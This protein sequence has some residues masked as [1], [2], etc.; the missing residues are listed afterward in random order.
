MTSAVGRI[1][2]AIGAIFFLV[3]GG[4]AFL[5]PS[6]FFDTVATWEPYNPHN[7]R[8]AGAFQLGIGVSLA[9]AL[10][11]QRGSLIALAGAS[12]AGVAHAISHGVDY[13][14]GGRT[15]DPYALGLLAL[16]FLVG[17]AAEIRAATLKVLIAGAAG[18][19]GIRT[20]SL[21]LARGTRYGV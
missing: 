11:A 13:G 5:V 20:S 14:E 4:W 6:S 1:A 18:D 10:W 9:A 21:L 19:L 8:D 7:L 15:T 17:L 12:A 3:F 16:L 2:L